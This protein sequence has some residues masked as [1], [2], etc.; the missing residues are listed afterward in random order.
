MRGAPL[1]RAIGT[2]GSASSTARIKATSSSARAIT[3]TVSSVPDCSLTPTR[4]T[5]PKVGL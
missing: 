1:S 2:G 3:P 5:S 4:L